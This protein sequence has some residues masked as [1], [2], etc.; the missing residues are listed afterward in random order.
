MWHSRAAICLLMFASV[1]SAQ[2]YIISTVAGG[3]PPPAPVA[4]TSA[5]FL[6]ANS[7]ATDTSG[8]AYFIASYCVFKLDASGVMTRVAGNGKPGYSGDGGPATSAQLFPGLSNGL[9]VDGQGNIFLSDRSSVRRISPGGTITTV[10]GSASA[11]D[12]GD[13]GPAASAQL[14][15]P[16][17][18]AVD[19][20]GDL[21]IA[22]DNRARKISPNGI[23]TTIAGNGK[24]GYAGDGGPAANA[25]LSSPSG[26]AIDAEGNI[27][28]ADYG[29]ARIR[30][31]SQDGT[32][33]TVA[34]G[35]TTTAGDGG[36]ATS[37][38][39]FAPI[40]LAIDRQDNLFIAEQTASRVRK[41]SPN[42]IIATV[43]GNGSATTSGDGGPTLVVGPR[44][45]AVDPQGNVFVTDNRQLIRKVSPDGVIR[46]VAGG[47]TLGAVVGGPAGSAQIG[48]ASGVAVDAQGNLF[49]A[50]RVANRVWKV[51]PAGTISTAAGTGVSGYSGDGGPAISAMLAGPAGVAVDAQSNIF[52]G[53]SVN[54]RIRRVS[55]DGTITTVA[56][57]GTS[58]YSGDGGTASTAQLSRPSALTIG[59]RGNLFVYEAL[60]FVI[61]NVSADG[62]ITTAAGTGKSGYSGDGSLA[63]KAQLGSSSTVALVADAQGSLFI[64]DLINQRVRKVSTDGIITTVAGTGTAGY[65]GEGVPAVNSPL[66]NPAGVAIDAAGNLVVCESGT[67]RIR[68]IS[69]AGI[70]TTV[71]GSIYTQAYSGDGGTAAN[72]RFTQP[73]AITLDGQGDLY[74]SDVIGVAV[75]RLHPT[76]RSVLI[77]AVLDAASQSAGPLSPGKIVVVYGAG[78]GAATLVQN[79]PTGGVYGAQLAGTS[80]NFNGIAAP[81]VYTSA[82]QVAAIVPYGITGAAAQVTVT[83]QGETSPSV[84]VPVAAVAPSLF[85]L[86][87]TGGGQAAAVN[88]ADGSINT[89]ANPVKIGDYISLFATGE[90]QTTPGS[91]DGKLAAGAVLPQPNL[92]VSATI[93]GLPAVVYYA[94]AAPGEVAGLMQVNLQIPRGIQSGGY[95]PV[96]LHVGNAGTVS[97]AV[98]IAVADATALPTASGRRATSIR[99]YSGA[100]RTIAYGICG[101]ALSR[102]FA[103]QSAC[104]RPQAERALSSRSTSYSTRRMAGLDS[105][106]KR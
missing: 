84:A 68:K 21:F 56:G 97:D 104:G 64:A 53:D 24:A 94:G 32:I 10:A 79:N 43:A 101:L 2:Q 59:P 37:A 33:T 75:R 98:W 38:Q 55:A 92:P 17:G 88:A 90:G 6:P 50:D 60:N 35:G 67:Q 44:S 40:G 7:V 69:A 83:Y 96:V 61:R 4:A 13:G 78:L 23:I 8:N 48:D 106:S 42:G 28:V 22:D 93:G 25:Q 74:V 95:V 14:I 41:V 62:V 82:T 99:S 15:Q 16:Y 3:A 39:L 34:G 57:T 9:T 58:G 11:G 54:N 27:F 51:S 65:G 36:S 81:L 80:V 73:G 12:S 47:G 5:S 31:I 103:T 85:T 76:N 100:A 63:T 87:Q 46:T 102:I 26:L 18:L 89:A 52:I 29:N 86:N 91:V 72:A 19:S 66:F 45:V 70:I 71:A 105:S 77:G 1:A 49:I 30:K 20:R